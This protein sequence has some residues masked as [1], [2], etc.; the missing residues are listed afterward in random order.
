MKVSLLII[1]IISILTVVFTQEPTDNKQDQ[2]EIIVDEVKKAFD[3]VSETAQKTDDNQEEQPEELDEDA[4][5][6]EAI[7]LLGLDKKEVL[8]RNDFKKFI[9]FLMTKNE[10]MENLQDNEKE[11]VQFVVEK[12]VASVP[13]EFNKNDLKEIVTSDKLRRTL[14]EAVAEKLG[15]NPDDLMGGQNAGGND[16]QEDVNVDDDS[17]FEDKTGGTDL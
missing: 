7:V 15:I 5:L 2:E 17:K 13:E 10:N 9:E 16:E 8:N 14:S 6:N 4:A 3:E 1:L 11:L 12:A